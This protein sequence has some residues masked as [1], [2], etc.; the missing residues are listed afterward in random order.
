M[1]R[2][3][4]RELQLRAA[5]ILVAGGLVFLQAGPGLTG[6]GQTIYAEESA[7]DDAGNEAGD[8][9][10][11]G[12][13]SITREYITDDAGNPKK[14]PDGYAIIERET[15][16]EGRVIRETFLDLTNRAETCILG[17]TELPIIYEKYRDGVTCRKV[18][19]PLTLGVL[20]MKREYDAL[21]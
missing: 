2:E 1:K 9:A 5:G 10:G 7:E 20:K 17:C 15:D 6:V 11:D 3:K 12:T 18:Y 8:N 16:A 21:S 19:D 4:V 14:G 13:E